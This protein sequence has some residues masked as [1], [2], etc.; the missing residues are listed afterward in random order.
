MDPNPNPPIKIEDRKYLRPDGT[1]I[2]YHLIQDGVLEGGTKQRGLWKLVDSSN[3]KEYIYAGPPSGFAQM[4]LAMCCSHLGKKAKVFLSGTKKSEI[5]KKAE[6]EYG[7]ETVCIPGD[8]AKTQEEA[9]KY[10]KSHPGTYLLNFGADSPEFKSL[11]KQALE[12]ALGKTK[13]PKRVWV[14]VGSGCLIKVLGEIWPKTQFMPVR[15]GK[16]IWEDQFTPDLWSRMGGRENI[17][18]LR[19]VDDPKLPKVKGHLYQRF[20]DPA[21]LQPPYPSVANYDAKAWQRFVE[22]GQDGD[23]IWNV[24]Q[25][26]STLGGYPKKPPRASFA[27]VPM[28]YNGSD[29]LS[30]LTEGKDK[31]KGKIGDSKIETALEALIPTLPAEKSAWVLRQLILKKF[32]KDQ[33]LEVD[34]KDLQV[35]ENTFKVTNVRIG[36]LIQ[37]LSQWGYISYPWK[38]YFINGLQDRFKALKKYEARVSREIY[39]LQNIDLKSQLLRET[40][41]YK[42]RPVTFV[43]KKDDYENF[44][45]ITDAT[46]LEEVRVKCTRSDQNQSAYDFWYTHASQVVT[47]LLDRKNGLTPFSLRE[48]LYEMH[49]ECT[50]FKPTLALSI[51][52]FFNAKKVLDFSTGR[53]DRL[54]G[55]MAAEVDSYVGYDPDTSLRE[56]HEVLLKKFDPLSKT[57]VNIEYIPFEDSNLENFEDFD[58]VF[59]SPPFF[60]FEVYGSGESKEGQSIVRYPTL[61][62]WLAKFLFVSL[63][64]AWS[65]LTVGGHIAI[66]ITDVYKTRVVEAMLLSALSYLEGAK[67]VGVLASIGDQG[68]HRPIWV[69]EKVEVEDAKVKKQALVDLK[70]YHP[71]VT[72]F[73]EDF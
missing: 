48:E 64:K 53:G 37:S 41:S 29:V 4:A 28:I 49:K 39:K 50:Q 54:T 32:V 62:E 30:I 47:R 9:R 16:N 24:A 15:V 66:H 18:R 38:R 68:R 63:E 44:D 25:D 51:Y 12:E 59:T 5:T 10:V 13:P 43:S 55:A 57:V 8:L 70:K 17:D 42:G 69:L 14:T 31:T 27:D 72:K 20:S 22:Y 45:V 65:H 61:D 11:L 36:A 3:A 58:L 35:F 52:K 21:P 6:V 7:L 40:S 19:V 1:V 33:K 67:Y 26:P 2:K 73:L 60:D 56:G 23:Y 71:G 46:V 34:Y